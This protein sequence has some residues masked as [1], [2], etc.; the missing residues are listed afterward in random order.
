M[1]NHKPIQAIEAS[2]I[3]RDQSF[4]LWFEWVLRIGWRVIQVRRVKIKKV[5]ALAVLVALAAL[6]PLV[7]ALSYLLFALRLELVG[8]DG[9]WVISDADTEGAVSVGLLPVLGSIFHLCLGSF[10]FATAGILSFL[11]FRRLWR[12]IK[13]FPQ[14]FNEKVAHKGQDCQEREGSIKS[15][16]QP[17]KVALV[18]QLFPWLK[19]KLNPGVKDNDGQVKPFTPWLIFFAITL[20]GLHYLSTTVFQVLVIL[21]LL[22]AFIQLFVALANKM[23]LRTVT[24]VLIVLGGVLLSTPQLTPA[25]FFVVLF[26]LL[27]V[28]TYFF[29][30]NQIAPKVDGVKLVPGEIPTDK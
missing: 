9:G 20:S 18:A 25:E 30:S 13:T 19:R 14:S 26:E 29:F 12:A 6:A 23:H 4:Q 16:D 8:L 28:F 11:V 22:Y 3:K 7:I 21:A 17:S 5:S 1:E 2:Q 24:W 15:E 10:I 27:S